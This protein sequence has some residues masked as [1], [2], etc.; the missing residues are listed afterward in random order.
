V[1]SGRRPCGRPP[2]ER[3][4]SRLEELREDLWL[5]RAKLRRILMSDDVVQ[6]SVGSRNARR[7]EVQLEQLRK[8]IKDLQD[9]IAV[10]ERGSGMVAV[11]VVPRDW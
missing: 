10:E 5:A 9:E 8:L 7:N 4:K 11:A 2:P 1:N 6:Y 3:P